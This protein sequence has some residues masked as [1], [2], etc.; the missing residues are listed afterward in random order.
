M[1]FNEIYEGLLQGKKYRLSYMN[2]NHY[3]Y[4]NKTYGVFK[5]QSNKK[6]TFTIKTL[7]TSNDWEEYKEDKTEIYYKY[8]GC[9]CYFYDNSNVKHYVLGILDSI[10][11]NYNKPFIRKVGNIKFAYSNC[12]PVKPEDI[13]FYK[14]KE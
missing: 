12:E 6:V 5:D 8:I 3:I 13:K 1:K 9:L 4:Y 2:K 10:D 7:M 11:L 14:E